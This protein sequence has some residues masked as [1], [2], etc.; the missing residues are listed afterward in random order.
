MRAGQG[1]RLWAPSVDAEAALKVQLV[2]EPCPKQDVSAAGSKRGLKEDA[3]AVESS[4]QGLMSQA[5]R[6]SP[7]AVASA[8]GTQPSPQACRLGGLD[9]VSFKSGPFHSSV[10]PRH[11]LRAVSRAVG[12]ARLPEPGGGPTLGPVFLSSVLGA[13]QAGLT[14]TR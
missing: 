11:P 6:R 3:G 13:G 2:S 4:R 7:S 5:G 12:R 8:A 10:G 9:A 1:G 14:R